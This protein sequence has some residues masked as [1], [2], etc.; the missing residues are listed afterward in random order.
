MSP[1]QEEAK[2][3]ILELVA[4]SENKQI[5]INKLD[6]ACKAA[7]ISKH[8]VED[9]RAS[10]VKDGILTRKSFGFGAEKK[11][12]VLLPIKRAGSKVQTPYL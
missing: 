8:V 2:E 7:G 9:A 10:L 5:E 3:F 4:D 1:K 11:W 12:Y 6:A